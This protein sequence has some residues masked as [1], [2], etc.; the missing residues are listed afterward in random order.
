MSARTKA[1]KA[2]EVGPGSPLSKADHAYTMIRERILAGDPKPG[3]RLV[4]EQLA[5]ELD[6]SAVPVREAIRRLEAEGYITYTRN[7]GATVGSIDL[8]RYPE[9]V[10][11]LAV[12]EAA[13]T[14]FAMPH[15]TPDDLAEARRINHDMRRSVE[16]LDPDRFTQMNH[17]FH[18]TLYCRCPNA[19]ILDM[20]NREWIL[21]VIRVRISSAVRNFH[22]GVRVLVVVS[23]DGRQ[24]WDDRA[25]RWLSWC[26]AT[27]SATHSN[28]GRV[29]RRLH[30]RSRCGAGS[31][32][33][34]PRAARTARSL[35]GLV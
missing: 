34:V 12:L 31:C 19:H 33:L 1:P 16:D 9:T 24:R 3:Q 4:I 17:Q 21:L 35:S 13:A 15:L 32:W 18:A 6:I 7:V 20:V 10:E 22:V 23:N 2:I 27:R 29:V 26:S 25:R 11:A 30:R 5:R 14:A 8:S 28:D